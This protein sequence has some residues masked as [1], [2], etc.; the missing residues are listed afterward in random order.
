MTNYLFIAISLDGY[1]ARVDGGI[2]WLFEIPNPEGSDYGYNNFIKN[3]DAILM[4]RITFEKVL[5]FGS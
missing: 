1:I 2:D 5:T 4:G 3:I